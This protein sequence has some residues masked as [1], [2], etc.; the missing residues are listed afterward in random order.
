[1][2]GRAKHLVTPAKAGACY[3][4]RN[5]CRASR[6][7]DGIQ[8]MNLSIP[9]NA[10]GL[11]DALVDK[12]A[13]SAASLGASAGATAAVGKDVEK[14]AKD[15]ESVLL[16]QVLQQMKATIPESGLEEDSA[17]QQVQGIFYSYLAQDVAS[18]G[19]VGLWKQLAR[20]IKSATEA[21]QASPS[22]MNAIAPE[23]AK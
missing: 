23:H 10:T 2:G 5:V 16:D 14:V 19:G 12:T 4:A 22:P 21:H 8:Y 3:E 20:Q 9:T 18:K 11:S 1:M 17:N 6:L 15:F 13:R 7:E